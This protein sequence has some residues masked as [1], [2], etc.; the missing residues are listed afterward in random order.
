VVDDGLAVVLHH[1]LLDIGLGDVEALAQ[2]VERRRLHADPPLSAG[3]PAD[4]L[5][6]QRAAEVVRTTL[7][8]RL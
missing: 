1:V 3:H 8:D 5:L 2:A 7:Q 6:H 4:R